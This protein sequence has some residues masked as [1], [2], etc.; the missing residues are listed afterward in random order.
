MHYL[1]LILTFLVVQSAYADDKPKVCLNMIVKNETQ[2]IKRGLTSVKPL[3][4]YWV[5][6]DT[7]STDGTQEMIKEFMADIPGELHERPWINFSHNRNQALDLAKDKADYLLF[8][9]AD[10]ELVHA[11]EF[12]F[13]ALD[14]DFYYAVT[15]LSGSKYHRVQL[16]KSALNWKWVGVVHEAVIAD[17][18]RSSATLEGIVNTPH[19]DGARSHDP[20]KFLKDAKLLEED[21]KT[22]P[23]NTRSVFYLAQSYYDAGEYALAL[24]NYEKR[25]QMKGWDQEVYWSLLKVAMLHELMNDPMET[26]AD[27]YMR[28]FYYRPSR[29]ESLYHLANLNRRRGN[30][31]KG[32]EL[33]Q[34]AL[35]IPRSQDILFVEKWLYDYGLEL[36]YSVCAYWTAR[37]SECKRIS[38]DLLS[39]TDLPEDIRTC[40][41]RNLQF[42]NEKLGIKSAEG[43]AVAGR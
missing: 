27:S 36:E 19:P 21:L 16:I 32:Y 3:I 31:V 9:D 4:D 24:Q 8:L 13:P 1:R 12:Q 38:E 2:V 14:K 15:E 17:N 43:S 41:T 40:V 37:F 26:I 11:P 5:I 42:A 33:T 20:Q 18:A 6:V 35:N 29:I 28:A 30:Y 34:I 10:E 23:H 7:G 25:A 39:K 22:D